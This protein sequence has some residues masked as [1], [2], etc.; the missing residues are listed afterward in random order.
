[1]G[2][3]IAEDLR[4]ALKTC[5][6]DREVLASGLEFQHPAET[7]ESNLKVDLTS[8]V[9][10]LFSDVGVVFLIRVGQREND[11]EDFLWGD[12]FK[13]LMIS[14]VIVEVLEEHLDAVLVGAVVAPELAALGFAIPSSF[15]HSKSWFHSGAI[16]GPAVSGDVGV[17]AFHESVPSG[18][19]AQ[20]CGAFS[21]EE[22]A[23]M[24]EEE[25]VRTGLKSGTLGIVEDEEARSFKDRIGGWD[26]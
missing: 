3:G 5:G 19:K 1:M 24:G 25:F 22:A 13:E 9:D 15:A 10:L 26:F 2:E 16:F 6:L 17:E 20:G 23:Y 14:R 18:A 4:T 21:R 12:D 7:V 8:E 11:V